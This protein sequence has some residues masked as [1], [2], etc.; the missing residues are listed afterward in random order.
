M[1][2]KNGIDQTEEFFKEVCKSERSYFFYIDA[3]YLRCL[4]LVYCKGDASTKSLWLARMFNSHRFTTTREII[5]KICRLTSTDMYAL[6]SIV[7]KKMVLSVSDVR[8]MHRVCDE[9]LPSVFIMHVK[10]E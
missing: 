4:A 6:G 3:D 1:L 7:N 9:M 5:S 10:P 8:K 2:G